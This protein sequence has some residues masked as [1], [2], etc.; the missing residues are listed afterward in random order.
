M[1][2]QSPLLLWFSPSPWTRH[3]LVS[4]DPVTENRGADPDIHSQARLTSP[5]YL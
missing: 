2:G 4:P 5:F 1:G 3:S